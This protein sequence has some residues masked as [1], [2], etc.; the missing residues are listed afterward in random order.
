MFMLYY[1]L[2]TTE[3]GSKWYQRNIVIIPLLILFFPV[4]LILM[5]KYAN[6]SR[7]AKITVT[8]LTIAVF[9]FSRTS[10][11]SNK[12]TTEVSGTNTSTP[13]AQQTVTTKPTNSPEPTGTELNAEVRFNE[14]AFQI[15]NKDGKDWTNC[16]LAL[17]SGL[18]GGGYTYKT[19]VIPANDPLFI[20]F[21]EFTK[22]DGTRFNSDETKHQ[23]LSISCKEGFNYFTTK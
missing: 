22:S 13:S 7:N 2:M 3:T 19:D 14:V 1:P 5:W 10:Q 15:T 16:R 12:R 18:L 6:W 9:I 20:P 21:R 23:S 8:L 4:G 17:N 11:N